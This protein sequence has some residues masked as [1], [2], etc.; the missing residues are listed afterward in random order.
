MSPSRD[1]GDDSELIAVANRRGEA[2]AEADVFVVEIEGHERIRRGIV[3]K[4]RARTEA[5]GDV[6]DRFAH[7]GADAERSAAIGEAGQYAGKEI[8]SFIC[9]CAGGQCLDAYAG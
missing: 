1:G 2:T 8:V 3:D 9:G 6:G 7:G 4:T 5:T